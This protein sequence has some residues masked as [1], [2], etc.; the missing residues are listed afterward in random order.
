MAAIIKITDVGRGLKP[1]GPAKG[2]NGKQSVMTAIRK[3][4]ISKYFPGLLLKKGL[5]LLITST[6]MDAEMTDSVNQP[7]LNCSIIPGS[8]RS[9]I[10]KVM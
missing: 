8:R 6:I 1:K 9:R 10:P 2:V 4:A 3:V 7:V 5:L